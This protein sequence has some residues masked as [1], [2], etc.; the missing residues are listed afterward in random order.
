MNVLQSITRLLTDPPPVLAFELTE[1]GVS[2]AR[3]GARVELDFEALKPG[4]ISVSPLRDNILNGEELAAAVRGLAPANGS[5]KRRDVALILPDYCAR[6]SVLDFDQ[7]PSDPKDQQSLVRFR[8]KKSVPFDVESAALSY[9]VQPHSGKRLDVVA[10]IAPL[11]IISRYEAP[12]R[13]SGMNPG[14]VTTSSLAALSLVP[15]GGIVV[16]AKLTDRVLTVMVLEK[17]VLKLVRCLELSERDLSEVA[18]DL[19]PT[20]VYVE[21]NLGAQAERLLLCGF[22]AGFEE[23]REQFEQGLGIAVEPVRSALLTPGENNAGLLGYLRS[24]AVT[25]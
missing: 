18:A 6:I 13:A 19:Y 16:V 25:N 9:W 2:V 3:L 1:S 11:E 12:F 17:G 8:L 5:R 22:G 21:D 23:A 10:V 24:V 14:M 20:F 15:E 4:V 7:F